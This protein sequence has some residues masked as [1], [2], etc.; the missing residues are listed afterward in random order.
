MFPNPYDEYMKSAKWKAFCREMLKQADYRC[1]K[2]KVRRF[3]D[4][5]GYN[6]ILQVHHLNYDRLE[7]ELPEDVV[8]LCK[9]CHEEEDE[10]RRS[11]DRK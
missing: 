6:I 3:V 4:A 5:F 2:C 1:Q 9:R 11:Q 10:F 7:N 8:V